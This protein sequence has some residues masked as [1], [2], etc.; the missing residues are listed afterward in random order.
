MTYFGGRNKEK[1]GKR[2]AWIHSKEIKFKMSLMSCKHRGHN[3]VWHGFLAS[4]FGISF[5]RAF[6]TKRITPAFKHVL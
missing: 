6:K 4:R 3:I 1:E 5:N 2:E